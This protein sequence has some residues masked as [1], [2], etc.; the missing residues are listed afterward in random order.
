MPEKLI[1]VKGKNYLIHPSCLQDLMN[2]YRDDVRYGGSSSDES[3]QEWLDRYANE[4]MLAKYG[5]RKAE[6]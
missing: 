3:F 2:E 6:D 5:A 1:T 4:T